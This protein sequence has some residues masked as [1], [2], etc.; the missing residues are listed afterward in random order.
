MIQVE[1]IYSHKTANG[2]C[3]QRQYVPADG[4]DYERVM[5]IFLQKPE[6]YTLLDIKLITR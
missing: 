1:F 5:D 2:D 3:V 4:K 6:E